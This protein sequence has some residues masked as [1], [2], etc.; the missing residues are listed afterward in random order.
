ML[1]VIV[2]SFAVAWQ[3]AQVIDRIAVTVD[4]HAITLSDVLEEIRFAALLDG[5][6]PEFSSTRKREA[7]ERLIERHLLARD[8]ELARFPPPTDADVEAFIAQLR[9]ARKLDGDAWQ[10]ELARYQIAPAQLHAG[11]KQRLAV[12]RYVEFRFRPQARSADADDRV[13]QLVD[14]WLKEARQRARIRWREAA[15]Q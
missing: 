2:C 6:T 10:A 3:T 4:E 13:N 8:M 12:L 11:L 14:A 15:F 1:A 5:V 7:A 9:A